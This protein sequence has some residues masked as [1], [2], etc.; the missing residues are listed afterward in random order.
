VVHATSVEIVNDGQDGT[1]AIVRACGPDDLLDY[2]NPS[3]QVAEFGVEVPNGVD[4]EDRPIEACTE[5]K[6]GLGARRVEVTTTVFNLS[7]SPRGSSS[8]TS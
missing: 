6:L 2:V 4:D 8:A 1:P 7:H 5:Y 3:S